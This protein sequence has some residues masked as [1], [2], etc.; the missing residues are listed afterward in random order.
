[1]TLQFPGRQYSKVSLMVH[2]NRVEISAQKSQGFDV[3]PV[4]DFPGALGRVKASFAN[5]HRL[6]G[7]DPP[8]AL[9]SCLQ[10]PERR[11]D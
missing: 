8:S 2:R 3:A 9:P 7:L 4:L 11:Q 6:R 1:M 10:L 5:A